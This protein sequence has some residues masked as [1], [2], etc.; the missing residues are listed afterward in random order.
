MTSIY[1]FLAIWNS[2]LTFE[3]SANKLF[4]YHLCSLILF[5]RFVAIDFTILI[6]CV[7]YTNYSISIMNDTMSHDQV[8]CYPYSCS[9]M[10]RLGF[11]MITNLFFHMNNIEAYSSEPEQYWP[12][13]YFCLPFTLTYCIEKREICS[14][15]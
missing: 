11:L 2:N 13:L 5:L 6:L 14:H 10:D 15:I 3:F 9:E 1:N 7:T 8:A 4:S 12:W